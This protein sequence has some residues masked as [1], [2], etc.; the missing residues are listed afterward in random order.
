MLFGV[1]IAVLVKDGK[2]PEPIMTMLWRLYV[3]GPATPGI[4]RKSANARFGIHVWYVHIEIVAGWCSSWRI[5]STTGWQL[6][7][8][9]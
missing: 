9:R 3:E 7:L 8:R 5:G 2:F 4:F 1:P 6:T